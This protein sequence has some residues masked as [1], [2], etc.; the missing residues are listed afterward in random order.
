MRRSAC[1]VRAC[2][3]L[4][5]G[6]FAHALLRG[7]GPSLQM[8]RRLVKPWHVGRLHGE[9][10]SKGGVCHLETRP[11]PMARRATPQPTKSQLAAPNL[12]TNYGSPNRS[13]TGDPLMPYQSLAIRGYVA[14]GNAIGDIWFTPRGAN[15]AIPTRVRDS[16]KWTPSPL[17]RSAVYPIASFY[18]RLR[19]LD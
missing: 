14:S 15:A 16:P 2:S 10:V 9:A 11:S 18:Y 5:I 17:R 3:T 1:S 13:N 8:P 7:F 19:L 4:Q 6:R 12:T